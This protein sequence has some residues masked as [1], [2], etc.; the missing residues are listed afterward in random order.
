MEFGSL[1]TGLVTGLREGVEAALIVGIILA[2]LSQTGNRAHFPKI[3]IGTI[4]AALVSLLLGVVL[5]VTVREFQEPYEQL[6]EATTMLLAAGVLTWMLFW[7]RR[8]SRS[9]RGHLQA[10]VDRV[11]SDGGGWG[12]AFLAFTAVIREGIETSL[13]LVGQVNAAAATE[14]GG[15]TAVLVGALVGL[16]IAVVIGWM[17]YVGARRIN[18]GTFFRWTGLALIFIAAGLVSRAIHELV[19]IGVVSVGT[20][21]AFNLA[22]V[23]P[24]DSGPGLF[25]R[26]LLGYSSSPEV[27]T[28]IAYLLYL[29]P[30]LLLYLRPVPVAKAA[31]QRP[32]T[33]G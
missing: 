6:F 20:Q 15:E 18:Y 14:A 12:L 27:V 3:W 4:T 32:A 25:L 22:G 24:E 1:T 7:M 19:E 2:Y 9:V 33:I 30:V 11:L 28:V 26:A 5:F 17:V 31:G 10:S 29:V 23:L 16:G 21:P 13:F 8:T